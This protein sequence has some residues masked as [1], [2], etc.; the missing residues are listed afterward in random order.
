M[1]NKYIRKEKAN[2]TTE[3]Q[4]DNIRNQNTSFILLQLLSSMIV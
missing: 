4:Q 2:G 1:D 3:I